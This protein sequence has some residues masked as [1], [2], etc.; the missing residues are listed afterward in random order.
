MFER[1]GC[2]D[3][4]INAGFFIFDLYT[5]EYTREDLGLL[6]NEAFMTTCACMKMS[7]DSPNV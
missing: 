2:C 6:S 4:N 5:K 1:S 7:P 3:N